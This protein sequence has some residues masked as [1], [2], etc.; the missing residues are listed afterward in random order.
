MACLRWYPVSAANSSRIH[1]FS[2]G[3]LRRYRSA[4]AVRLL[5]RSVFF[6]SFSRCCSGR[7]NCGRAPSG[8]VWRPIRGR[9]SRSRVAVSDRRAR[10]SFRGFT[11]QSSHGTRRRAWRRQGCSGS[12]RPVDCA[13]AWKR[14]RCP[15]WRLNRRKMRVCHPAWTP[16]TVPTQPTGAFVFD[17]LG[18]DIRRF[19][20]GRFSMSPGGQFRVSL[21]KWRLITRSPTTHQPARRPLRRDV[22]SNRTP[23]PALAGKASFRVLASAEYVINLSAGFSRPWD[24]QES[25]GHG[26]NTGRPDPV[27]VGGAKWGKVLSPQ[28]A[29]PPSASCPS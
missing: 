8:V 27:G 13:A 20:G 14:A 18:H 9:C 3:V 29:S 2:A 7:P 10:V 25:P 28:Q 23:V 12:G 17:D 26:S 5:P 6:P 19:F 11:R 4:T 15:R 22:V 16:K 21:D 1:P 24:N